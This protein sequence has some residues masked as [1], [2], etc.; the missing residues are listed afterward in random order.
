MP[1]FGI[2]EGECQVGFRAAWRSPSK[3]RGGTS[4]T[5][6]RRMDELRATSCGLFSF[7]VGGVGLASFDRLFC[8]LVFVQVGGMVGL[9]LL[10]LLT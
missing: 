5:F 3:S 10:G 7:T 8:R 4:F 9:M 6:L 2:Y 1:T